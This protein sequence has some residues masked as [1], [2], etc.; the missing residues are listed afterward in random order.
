MNQSGSAHVIIIVVLAIA[1]IGALGFTFWQNI[2]NKTPA[3]ADRISS[4]ADC[5]KSQGSITQQTYPETCVTKAG[6]RFTNTNQK[7]EPA[8][9]KKYC[10]LS[11]KLCFDYP[12]DWTIS[13]K[14]YDA[15]A[16]GKTDDIIISDSTGKS[17]LKLTSGLTGLGGTCG[18]ELGSYAKIVKTHTTNLT[19]YTVTEPT[20]DYN[21]ATAYV[22]NE[23]SY[24]GKNTQWSTNMFISTSK[25]AMTIGNIGICDIGIPA[26][27][28][29]NAAT[30]LPDNGHGALTFGLYYG[31]NGNYTY[32]TE[33]DAAAALSSD[34]ANKA[35]AILQSAHY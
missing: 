4:Y 19:G 34:A 30:G 31:E 29:K 1:L 5:I 28:G 32:K 8:A 21:V 6:D 12:D 25:A 18:E 26:I 27:A 17:W 11:E 33:A 13:A 9:L 22:V 16:E 15:T 14:K 2:I 20:K 24:N 23:I 35:F 3:V 10:S 7:V